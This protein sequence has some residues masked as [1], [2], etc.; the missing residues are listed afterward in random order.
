MVYELIY[1]I[2]HKYR[3]RYPST[4]TAG[5]SNIAIVLGVFNETVIPLALVE[6]EIV[7]YHLI[8]NTRS[9]NNCL[10]SDYCVNILVRSC[11]YL[12]QFR[13][14]NVVAFQLASGHSC[15]W[16][17][18]IFNIRGLVKSFSTLWT[19]GCE[20]IH[21]FFKRAICKCVAEEYNI[22]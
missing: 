16:C 20:I 22:T 18:R 14:A 12:I 1:T 17:C 21:H 11:P 15:F 8:S 5:N 7:I 4:K 6:Y 10:V 3:S 2:D 9:W 13:P 19:Y